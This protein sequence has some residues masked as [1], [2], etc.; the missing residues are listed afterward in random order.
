[1]K[2]IVFKT[3]LQNDYQK[4]MLAPVISRMKGVARW[5]V[6]FMDKNKTLR[7]E[8]HGLKPQK[9]QEDITNAGFECKMMY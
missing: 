9:I 7:I 8:G 5:S 4:Q 6:D 2:A 1:M 3:N